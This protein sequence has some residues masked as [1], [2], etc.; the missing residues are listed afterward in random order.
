MREAYLLAGCPIAKV[1][2]RLW[3]WQVQT[4]RSAIAANE[5][6]KF[7]GLAIWQHEVLISEFHNP[8]LIQKA[9][10]LY[11][12]HSPFILKAVFVTHPGRNAG[13]IYYNWSLTAFL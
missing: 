5:K 10:L 6:P 13:V 11:R 1:I 12:K 7:S 3:R 9:S 8:L 4:L 2:N